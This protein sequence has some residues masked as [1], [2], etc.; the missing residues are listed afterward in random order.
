MHVNG[1]HSHTGPATAIDV[2]SAKLTC[3]RHAVDVPILVSH[4]VPDGPWGE[5]I[6]SELRTA[7][8]RVDVHI[9]RSG[10]A[11]RILAA[12]SGPDPVVVLISAEHPGTPAD[13]VRV[14]RGGGRLIAFSLDGCRPGIRCHGLDGL[15]AE[16]IRELLYG[17]I[18]GPRPHSSG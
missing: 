5:W 4:A 2:R 13:W 18:G 12:L 15:A 14:A 8:Y 1:R 11:D 9:A 6:A 17:L 16:E 7:G 10:F 3:V